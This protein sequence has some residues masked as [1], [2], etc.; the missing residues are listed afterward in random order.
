MYLD[1]D[2]FTKRA[3]A[4][5][6]IRNLKSEEIYGYVLKK[7]DIV[8]R[9]LQ[10]MYG[11]ISPS[12]IGCTKDPNGGYPFF[13]VPKNALEPIVEENKTPIDGPLGK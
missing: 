9:C 5:I 6:V 7:G 8:Y 4:Y 1:K 10:H 11:C 3:P 13:E 2:R 12:G